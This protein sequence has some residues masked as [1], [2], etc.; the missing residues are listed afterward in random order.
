MR[1][2]LLGGNGFG[3]V[4]A[5]S[6]KNLGIE[7]SV[8]SRNQDILNNYRD[9]FGVLETFS[10]LDAAI[11]SD[12]DAVDIVLPH[13][14][15]LKYSKKAM[16][17]GKHVL[18][19][20]PIASTIEEARE[21]I[22]FARE[23]KVKLMVAEQYYF[24][25]ALTEVLKLLSKNVIGKVHTIIVRDQRLYSKTGWRTE[26]KIMGGGSL[27]D[28]GV[29][30][31]EAMLDFGGPIEKMHSYTYHGGS[32]LEGEDNTL[33]LFTF[34]N[35]VHG[36]FYYSW[37]YPHAPQL[38]AYEIIGTEGSIIEDLESKPKVD[39]KY[40]EFPRHAFGL[41]VV[42]G[43]VYQIEIH[44]VFDKEISG[45]INAIRNDTGVPYPPEQALRNLETIMEIYSH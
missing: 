7:F 31:I 30:Y 27:I 23:K 44:D 8:F 5:K 19:E 40:Q 12:Y 43:K 2:L 22:S 1:V 14:L 34:R 35:G 18:I 3:K 41:P 24:D 21:M 26:Q 11:N 6:F 33:A 9:E 25:S 17:R 20:K 13:N 36:M 38:P 45:F 16:E 4:H 42:N 15:H 28:G 32:S 39:F 29:H 10:D 37:A